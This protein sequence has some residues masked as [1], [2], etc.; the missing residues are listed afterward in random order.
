[1]EEA[2]VT[3]HSSRRGNVANGST[4][5]SVDMTQWDEIGVDGHSTVFETECE[6][7]G[8]KGKQQ[9]II[10]RKKYASS[11]ELLQ[12]VDVASRDGKEIQSIVLES[13]K[14]PESQ[15]SVDIQDMHI[16][17]NQSLLK[18]YVIVV[19]KYAKGR[20]KSVSSQ[21]HGNALIE[22]TPNFDCH[23]LKSPLI[24][25]TFSD[26]YLYD[27]CQLYLYEFGELDML[28][29]PRQC[30][31]Y[32]IVKLTVP[33]EVTQQPCADQSELQE[34]KSPGVENV[35]GFLGWRGPLYNKSKCLGEV[36]V[37]YFSHDKLPFTF[38]KTLNIKAKVRLEKLGNVFPQPVFLA[39][40]PYRARQ[41]AVV[42]G[43]NYYHYCQ[44]RAEKD[45][46]SGVDKL[47]LFLL[48]NNWVYAG[49]VEVG[50]GT[51]LYI[52]PTSEFTTNLGITSSDEKL[53]LHGLF[54]WKPV[55]SVGQPVACDSGSAPL[56]DATG[57]KPVAALDGRQRLP[58]EHEETSGICVDS[59]VTNSTLTTD[60]GAAVGDAVRSEKSPLPS[61]HEASRFR[62]SS[63]V[64]TLERRRSS[65]SSTKDEDGGA[66]KHDRG[67]TER[68]E[69]TVPASQP[70]ASQMSSS[71]TDAVAGAVTSNAT[72]LTDFPSNRALPDVI[73]SP[74]M[75]S[76]SDFSP[77]L[78]LRQETRSDDGVAPRALKRASQS[79]SNT[80]E[81]LDKV[82]GLTRQEKCQIGN[83]VY[84][85]GKRRSSEAKQKSD[86]SASGQSSLIEGLPSL[87]TTKKP[88]PERAAKRPRGRPPKAKKM[89][90]RAG[91]REKDVLASSTVDDG[92]GILTRNKKTKSGSRNKSLSVASSKSQSVECIL[93]SSSSQESLADDKTYLRK[94]NSGEMKLSNDPSCTHGLK[95]S[96]SSDSRRDDNKTEQSMEPSSLADSKRKVCTTALITDDGDGNGRSET[97]NGLLQLSGDGDKDEEK[98]TNDAP[99]TK[100]LMFPV[101][102]VL[103]KSLHRDSSSA[104]QQRTE[105]CEENATTATSV[106]TEITQCA[107]KRT[108]KNSDDHTHHTYPT[109]RSRLRLEGS[110]VGGMKG[111]LACNRE[112]DEHKNGEQS[113]LAETRMRLWLERKDDCLYDHNDSNIKGG[114]L[115]QGTPTRRQLRH[116]RTDDSDE[117]RRSVKR[118]SRHWNGDR[119]D[120]D[121][122]VKTCKL[123]EQ[124]S[125]KRKRLAAASRPSPTYA[126]SHFVETTVTT[127]T[128]GDDSRQDKHR[129]NDSGSRTDERRNTNG[130]KKTVEGSEESAVTVVGVPI[131]PLLSLNG[132]GEGREGVSGEDKELVQQDKNKTDED[133]RNCREEVRTKSPILSDISGASQCPK[134]DVKE[135]E[136]E[137]PCVVE[138]AS[139]SLSR[140]F[141][142]SV[143][144]D[145]RQSTARDED[146]PATRDFSTQTERSHVECTYKEMST[147]TDNDGAWR[148]AFVPSP[149]RWLQFSSRIP[150]SITSDEVNGV[151]VGTFSRLNAIV[152]KFEQTMIDGMGDRMSAGTRGLEHQIREYLSTARKE[153]DGTRRN[154][155]HHTDATVEDISPP[156]TSP[157]HD[158]A[159]ASAGV[160]SFP[161]A[162]DRFLSFQGNKQIADADHRPEQRLRERRKR[163]KRW[164]VMSIER[165]KLSDQD[166]S[167]E[168]RGMAGGSY[169]VNEHLPFSSAGS[170]TYPY[171]K[172]YSR[173][174]QSAYDGDSTPPLEE[175]SDYDDHDEQCRDM[176]VFRPVVG[177]LGQFTRTKSGYL[178]G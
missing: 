149:N 57:L 59:N 128:Y 40:P 161:R 45:A 90:G 106:D 31:P 108:G 165:E 58:I 120:G 170:S 155:R 47:I 75:S 137:T 77:P 148:E 129:V 35:S 103:S 160:V 99:D 82:V 60:I 66:A 95:R 61:T 32:A 96:Q 70:A 176:S 26:G 24:D 48:E 89:A 175:Y 174:N 69:M 105:K 33:E 64:Q 166:R 117:R 116:T 2:R 86:L 111:L 67:V 171:P 84:L 56:N 65:S 126:T 36:G 172:P 141:L 150:L 15:G 153:A 39:G 168:L 52:L 132:L 113:K 88:E 140:P 125:P 79:L 138:Q 6:A 104:S 12:A 30:V 71:C 173:S 151:A 20:V 114:D 159:F 109:L 139:L 177:R 1:M 43:S 49:V 8:E 154:D 23:S 14:K 130:E 110:H 3:S 41:G 9:F 94:R 5:S 119:V 146:R 11:S 144:C 55:V 37:Y 100:F 29:R 81:L 50:E 147:Q 73:F 123:P 16:V 93:V 44:I 98:T 163:K 91:K 145:T 92:D 53:C 164:D 118:S 121:V 38:E 136:N 115:S 54:C 25:G 162:I 143:T 97:D 112:S 135:K 4:S 18:E 178:I 127:K 34:L 76:N 78:K 142:L 158:G 107:D 21:L 68:V 124:S 72:L 122:D 17:K 134:N 27:S 74:D 62:G 80:F 22:P 156:A 13:M 152:G 63:C 51:K 101:K 19:F 133:S 87:S 102:K 42:R 85:Q 10:P 7:E 28:N 157:I 131:L 169:D 46:N 83:K 167:D